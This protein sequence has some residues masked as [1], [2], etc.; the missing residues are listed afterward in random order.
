MFAELKYN[1]IVV[2]KSDDNILEMLDDDSTQ[3]PIYYAH[4]P[5]ILVNGS[6]GIGTGFSTDVMCY[7]VEDIVK[8]V[9]SYLSNGMAQLILK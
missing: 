2:S 4:I 3:E 6:K 8:Y 1:T 5:M 7:S 9:K